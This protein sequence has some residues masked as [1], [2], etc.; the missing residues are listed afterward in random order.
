MVHERRFRAILREEGEHSC[1]LNFHFPQEITQFLKGRIVLIR[2][3]GNKAGP[4]HQARNLFPQFFQQG[5]QVRL[6]IPAIH[7][8]QNG[9]VAVL[10]GNIQI[11]HDL[12]FAGDHINEFIGSV[13][14]IEVVE[15][16][17]V[18]VQLAKLLQQFR[19]LMLAVEV[20]AVP[21]DV[22]SDDDQ[23]LHPGGGKLRRLVQ[24]LIHGTAA[25]LATA[26]GDH[27]VGTVIVAALSDPQIGIPRWCGQNALTALVGRVDIPQMAG[28]FA[29]FHHLGNGRGNIIIAAGTQQAVHLRQ[30]LKNILFITLGHAAGDQDLLHL[31]R[32]FQFCHL[33]NILDGFLTGGRQKST[34]IHHHH[35]AALRLGLDGVT[36][37]R[38]QGHHLLAVHLILGAAKRNE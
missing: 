15:P 22:L 8:L 35:V 31:T 1:P 11:F 9:I 17:P 26:G 6:G 38:T 34:G 28:F 36:C 29:L 12:R 37:F 19:K 21:G 4:Q 2:Q 5:Q 30:L 13:R 24:Q 32:L 33:Q 18:E 3:A 10:D 27:A 14:G 16:D 20:R 25:V 23:L 7:S